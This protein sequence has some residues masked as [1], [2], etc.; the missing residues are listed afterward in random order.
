MD[1]KVLQAVPLP[2]PICPLTNRL[3]LQNTRYTPINQQLV[4][5]YS[6]LMI[7]CNKGATLLI[8]PGEGS[9]EVAWEGVASRVSV[10][11]TVH[12]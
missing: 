12:Y 9:R 1:F 6:L 8:S 3:K 2:L 4:V 11:D 10:C 5:S 7:I